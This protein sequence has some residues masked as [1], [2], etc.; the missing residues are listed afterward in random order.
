MIKKIVILCILVPFFAANSFADDHMSSEGGNGAFSTLFVAAKDVDSYIASVRSNPALFKAIG[1]QAA[2]YCET[3]SGQDYSG[4][5][6]LWNAFSSVTAAMLGAEKYNP[7]KA[8]KAMA[9]QRDFKYGATWAPLKPFPRLDP[10]YERAMRIKVAPANLPA[11]IATISKLEKEVQSAGHDTF[12]NGLFAA[13]G[14]GKQEANTLYLKSVTADAATHGAVIDDY[15]SGAAWGNTY[16][17]ATALI[18]EVLN[19]QFEVCTQF[20]TAD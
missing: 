16:L 3:V 19:D 11:L 5:V 20:Y 1:A 13:I 14:G 15:L 17:E 10:G 9:S 8:P 6:M 18:D 2:G 4:Q 12:M 7:S